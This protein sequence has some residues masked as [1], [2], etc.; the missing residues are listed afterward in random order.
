MVNSRTSSVR[1]N[2]DDI[3]LPEFTNLNFLIYKVGRK[4]LSHSVSSVLS[5]YA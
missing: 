3:V 4:C 5:S 2:S 1:Q